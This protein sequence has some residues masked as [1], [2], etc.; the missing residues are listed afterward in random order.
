MSPHVFTPSGTFNPSDVRI[1]AARKQQKQRVYG[2]C[3]DILKRKADNFPRRL[4]H[5]RPPR[6]ATH[7]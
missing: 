3:V 4:N 5:H 1:Y 7:T 2:R 6:A